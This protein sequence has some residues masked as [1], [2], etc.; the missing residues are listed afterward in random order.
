MAL[1]L[2]DPFREVANLSR[3][4]DRL[5]EDR[6]LP[7][8]RWGEWTCEQIVGLPLDVSEE[9]DKYVVEASLPGV[10]PA[11]VEVSVQGNTLTISGTFNQARQ[12]GRNYLL[13][14]RSRGKFARALTLPAEVEAGKVE[15]RFADGIL[16][17]TLPKAPQ[18]Q[19]RKIAVKAGN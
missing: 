2:W 1:T 9:T 18:Y 15:A 3:V 14:E 7:T 17:L 11:D 8:Y 6:L 4:M 12:E 19:A 16:Q 10:K 5:F 13:R